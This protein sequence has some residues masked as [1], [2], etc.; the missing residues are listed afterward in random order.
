MMFVPDDLVYLTQCDWVLARIALFS[1]TFRVIFACSL[2]LSA[3]PCGL[4]TFS[5]LRLE[6]VEEPIAPLRRNTPGM[7]E[8]PQW[9]PVLVRL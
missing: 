8:D 4:F 5:C 3:V 6:G 1:S 9:F 2:D 7:R